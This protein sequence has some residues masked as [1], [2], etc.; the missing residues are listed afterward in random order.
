MIRLVN[1]GA[2]CID[3]IPYFFRLSEPLCRVHGCC[4]EANCLDLIY[5]QFYIWNHAFNR[6]TSLY[7]RRFC[8][9][10]QYFIWRNDVF[11]WS[12]IVVVT[13]SWCT[14]CMRFIQPINKEIFLLSN[15]STLLPCKRWNILT[16]GT[17][18]CNDINNESICSSWCPL[19][20]STFVRTG[21]LI[22]HLLKKTR[23]ACV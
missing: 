9:E 7:S 8:T 19:D 6:W 1:R 10:T 21:I 4:T 22:V 14:R 5:H 16:L 12:R 18:W 2:E 17:C 13:V 3:D 23:S 11:P 15:I 20:G